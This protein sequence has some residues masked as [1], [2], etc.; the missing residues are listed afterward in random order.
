MQTEQH[1]QPD[2]Q[3]ELNASQDIQ[4][5]NIETNDKHLSET[6]IAQLEEKANFTVPI[7]IFIL[8]WLMGLAS[9]SLLSISRNYDKFIGVI[10]LIMAI[11]FFVNI[12][13][14]MSAKTKLNSGGFIY[15]YNRKSRRVALWFLVGSIIFY[16]LVS[17]FGMA[18]LLR[19]YY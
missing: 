13:K 17:I 5:M 6:E 18:L 7:V 14:I 3:N 10:R 15:K 1:N 19:W 2:N 11:V 12:I 16:I 4:S 8:Y 9:Y